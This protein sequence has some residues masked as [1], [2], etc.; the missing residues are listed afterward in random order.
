M[1]NYEP[2][3]TISDKEECIQKKKKERVYNNGKGL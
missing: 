3:K 1:K 2:W